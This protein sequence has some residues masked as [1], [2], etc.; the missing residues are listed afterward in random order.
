MGK[1][2]ALAKIKNS[3][4]LIIDYLNRLNDSSPDHPIVA[5]CRDIIVMSSLSREPDTPSINGKEIY[6][7]F[8]ALF[9]SS[10]Q[11]IESDQ[12]ELITDV[13]SKKVD[14]T[15]TLALL[16]RFAGMCIT[17][18]LASGREYSFPDY[19]I[20]LSAYFL[21]LPNHQDE[22]VRTLSQKIY[23]TFK[24][25]KITLNYDLRKTVIEPLSEIT[26]LKA[27]T[28]KKILEF[29][30][31]ITEKQEKADD[32]IRKSDHYVEIIEKHKI[33]LGIDALA[34]SFE[35]FKEQKK[36]ERSIN[37]SAIGL[38]VTA[39]L[40]LPIGLFALGSFNTE[41]AI[42]PQI[43]RYL[44]FVSVEL[45]LLYFFRISIIQ[46]NSIQAQLLQLDLRIAAS[47]FV[48]EFS[49][50]KK[51]AA[52]DISKFESLVFSGIVADLEKTPSTFD[53]IKDIISSIKND[54]Q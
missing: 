43:I 31:V 35:V 46:F 18:I 14:I 29:Q 20:R 39:M 10:I 54:K 45:F 28:D 32:I 11:V 40:A 13:L 37:V 30:K 27:D 51:E 53:G 36:K 7:Q 48:Q 44:P 21:G 16:F 8:Y 49:S 1:E 47:K 24:T 50:F 26:T 19:F 2:A 4:Q 22:D 25:V 52:V 17:E 34:A 9:E 33:A 41:K 15:R 42:L 5:D 38:I 12:A 6:E 3:K 23:F